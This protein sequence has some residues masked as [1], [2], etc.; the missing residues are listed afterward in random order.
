MPLPG[1]LRDDKRGRRRKKIDFA[2]E[3]QQ[4]DDDDPSLSRA[5]Q[6]RSRSFFAISSRTTLL[7]APHSETVHEA[8]N[9]AHCAAVPPISVGDVLRFSGR[10]ITDVVCVC[11][12]PSQHHNT[13][14]LKEEVLW[15]EGGGGEE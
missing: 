6:S 7:V 1:V 9:P 14:T 13:R 5:D 10:L 2:S 4:H 8:T 12:Y 3:N 15:D 11:F